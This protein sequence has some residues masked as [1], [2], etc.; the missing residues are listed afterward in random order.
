MGKGGELT[1]G[2][3]F[4]ARPL[5]EIYFDLVKEFPLMH[6]KDENHLIQAQKML[7]DLLQHP[8][9]EG[10]EAYL[11]ALTD[12]VGVYE[13]KHE[14]IP[15]ASAGD[16]LRELVASSGL[17]QQKLARAVGIAQ[18]TISAVLNGSRKPTT[19]QMVKLAGYFRVSPAVF[20]PR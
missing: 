3:K 10:G 13:D 14:A 9:D 7:D 2:I 20:L 1:M 12:L 4:I 6:I 19:D 11:D 17:S 15:D 18:S 16:V 8:L 5:P